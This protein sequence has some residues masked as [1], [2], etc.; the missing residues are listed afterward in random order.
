M[1]LRTRGHSKGQALVEFA[2]VIPIFLLILFGALDLGRVIWANDIV[3][4]AAREGARYASV[5]GSSELTQVASKDEIRAH[6][7]ESL[8]AAG[9][10][11][12]VTVCYASVQI[13][14]QKSGCS[15]SQD[16]SGASNRRGALVTV[17][18]TTTVEIFTGSLLGMSNFTVNGT[19]TV[20][21]NN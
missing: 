12:V 21:I 19:S 3:A 15:G 2:V 18:V 11:P 7:L 4:N 8:V 9:Q 10:S 13:A 14:T 5:H 17:N 16:E 6:T 1:I 20:L